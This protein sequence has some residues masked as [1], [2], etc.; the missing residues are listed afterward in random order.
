MK[1]SCQIESA[2][3]PKL[4]PHRRLHFDKT[5][6]GWTIQAPERVFLLDGPGHAIVSRC[7]GDN[8]IAEIVDQICEAF[9]D[10]PRDMIAADVTALV[11]DFTDKGVMTL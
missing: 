6:D 10:S 4:A 11:R 2:S 3:R 5:R 8:S 9:P 7:N 1:G